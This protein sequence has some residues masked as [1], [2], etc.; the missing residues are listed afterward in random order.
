MPNADALGQPGSCFDAITLERRGY[1]ASR[2][3]G[4][5]GTG[6]HAMTARYCEFGRPIPLLL[7]KR[8]LL[9]RQESDNISSPLEVLAGRSVE[10]LCNAISLNR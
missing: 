5:R 10:R 3:I 9:L 7:K 2:Q 4:N 1:Q 6:M 8:V